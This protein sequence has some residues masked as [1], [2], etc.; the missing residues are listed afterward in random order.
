MQV[1]NPSIAP[2]SRGGYYLLT[3]CQFLFK[4]QKGGSTADKLQQ[5]ATF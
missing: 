2:I 1:F 4:K 3:A 5:L